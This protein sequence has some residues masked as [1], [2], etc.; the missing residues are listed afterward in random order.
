MRGVEQREAYTRLL[1][2]ALQDLVSKLS[3]LEGVRRISLFGSYARGRR[4]LFT[5]LDVLVIMET[6]LSFLERLRMLYQRVSVPVD[7]DLLCYTPE[8]FVALKERPFFKRLLDEEV[9]LYEK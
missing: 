6:P 3:Q 7:L 8:E 9:V 5:D 2:E 1:E 4:D